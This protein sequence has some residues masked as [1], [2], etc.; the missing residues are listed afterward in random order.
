[1]ARRTI[2]APTRYPW[3]FNGPANSRHQIEH[4]D[5]LPL[6]YLSSKI[7]GV[8]LFKP[9][10]VRR[11]DLV[12]AFNRIPVGRCPFVIGFESH[13]PRAFGIEGGRWWD[14]MTGMLAS[15]RC[16]GIVAI[17]DFARRMFLAQHE[18]ATKSAA[19]REILSG[20]LHMRLPNLALPPV[21]DLVQADE[22]GEIRLVFVGNH[23]A[24]KGGCVAVVMAELA[25][26][27]GIPLVVDIVSRLEMGGAIWTDPSDTETFKPY[28]ARLALPN[29]RVHRD[30]ANAEVLA[31]LRR[32]HVS[33]LTTF[34][35][36]FGYSALESL[37][38]GTPVLATR[39]GAL[40]EFIAHG[41]N[42]F[43]LDLPTT[44][45]GEWVHL[46][47]PDRAAPNFVR[48]WNDE[49]HRLAEEAL[50]ALVAVSGTAGR[51]RAMQQAA[52]RSVERFSQGQATAW[53]DDFYDRACSGI[54]PATRAHQLALAGSEA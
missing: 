1:M 39:Q 27:R 20:K 37:A 35:D 23:F 36:T 29:V 17:S 32:A 28:L 31:L 50:D 53:W 38:N 52:R 49:V 45:D 13:L 5:F 22:T 3:R 18:R 41:E 14:W 34:G 42:G 54:V 15:E 2:L 26:A 30:L 33:L 9:W 44:P 16:R 11:F 40:P 46:G 19:A 12:H 43:L 8:T 51:M 25:R 6:N 47:T 4:R 7:E 21:A 10:P 24:R 48:M